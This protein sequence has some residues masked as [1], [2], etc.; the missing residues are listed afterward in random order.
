MLCRAL[1]VAVVLKEV[2]ARQKFVLSPTACKTVKD[3]V[4]LLRTVF[5]GHM[6]VSA[7]WGGS[8]ASLWKP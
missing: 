3:T 7:W 4:S 2:G 1:L 6:L 5:D 8:W